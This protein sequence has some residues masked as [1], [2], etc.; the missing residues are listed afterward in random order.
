MNHEQEEARRLRLREEAI[1][2]MWHD[3]VSFN[4]AL[5][6]LQRAE[7]VIERQ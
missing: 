2:V 6:Q 7:G 5:D 4:E 3:D 1:E